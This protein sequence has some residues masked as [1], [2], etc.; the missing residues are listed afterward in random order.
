MLIVLNVVLAA[1]NVLPIPP[2]DGSRVADY[3]MPSPLRPAWE[4]FLQIGPMALIAVIFLPQV[5]GISLF[6]WPMFL[7][8]GLF[9]VLLRLVGG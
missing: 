6:T 7:I 3:L 1:F 4:S 9:E 2:L 5:M 8:A